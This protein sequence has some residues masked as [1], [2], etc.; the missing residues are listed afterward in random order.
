MIFYNILC[1]ATTKM[2]SLK[3]NQKDVIE[4]AI[5]RKMKGGGLSLPLGFGKTRTSICLGLT[6]NAGTILVVTSKT[7][8]VTWLS[9]IPKAFGPDFSFEYLHSSQVK[10]IGLWEPKPET[11]L[12]LTTPEVLVAAYKEYNLS[13][14]FLNHIIPEVFG[15]TILEYRTP[16]SPMLLQH[17][18]GP[19]YLYSNQWGCLIVDEIQNH[20]NIMSEK[21]RAI[22]CISASYRWGLSATMFDEPKPE[23]FLGYFTMLD[24]KGPRTRPDMIAHMSSE[25]KGFQTVIIHRDDNRE[26]VARPKYTEQIVTHE[27]TATELKIF[28]ESREILNLL[29]KELQIMK[30]NEDIDGMRLFSAYLLAMI[31]YIRQFL[32]CP[33]IPITSIYCDIA[34]FTERSKLSVMIAEKFNTLNITEWLNDTD[35][36]MSSRFKS[37]LGKVSNHPNERIIIFSCFRTTLT[38]L[39]NLTDEIGERKTFTITASSS[40]KARE[41][42]IKSFE[43]FPNG[44]LFLP[45]S[46][47]AEGLNLQCASVVM[48]MDLWWNSAKIQQAIGRVFRPGQASLEIFIYIFVSNTGMETEIIKKN[49]IKKE[50]LDELHVGTTDKK[51]PRMTLQQIVSVI[52]SNVN[53]EMLEKFRS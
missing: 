10:N 16:K 25:F 39:Q 30:E 24:I 45:Y 41:K 33:I 2:E 38:L 29:N 6:H 44:I 36:V 51:I 18:T 9:E 46:L 12:V 31:T 21:C 53:R 20:N 3:Q 37:V 23:R 4:E 49:I 40:I 50:I 42:I 17:H 47:G 28:K 35:S 7:L 27:L 14:L 13:M 32:V 8:G 19:G 22:S 11:K 48:L 43:A 52:N 5:D 15:P 34:D 1:I 26:F